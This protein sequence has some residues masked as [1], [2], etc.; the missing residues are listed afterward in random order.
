MESH[1]DGL[2]GVNLAVNSGKLSGEW[3]MNKSICIINQLVN[4]IRLPAY[5]AANLLKKGCKA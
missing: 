5:E 1:I 2:K 4:Y 3:I